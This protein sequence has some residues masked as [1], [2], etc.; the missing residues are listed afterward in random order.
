MPQTGY[1]DRAQVLTQFFHHIIIVGVTQP[2]P[3]PIP[4]MPM[5]SATQSPRGKGRCD[6][7]C[8]GESKA[9]SIFSPNQA[10]P[11]AGKIIGQ[12]GPFPGTMDKRHPI[13]FWRKA[14]STSAG[15]RTLSAFRR[16]VEDH[17]LPGFNVDLF[18]RLAGVDARI[19]CVIDQPFSIPGEV[20]VVIQVMVACIEGDLARGWQSFK[21]H[22][23][24][25]Q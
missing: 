21:R 12:P 2:L 20:L 9:A 22:G 19:A 25:L 4:L 15:H 13:I 17:S 14:G 1:P 3:A 6:V 24:S 5:G 7:S 11:S 10:S 8:I 23:S 18:N 16:A